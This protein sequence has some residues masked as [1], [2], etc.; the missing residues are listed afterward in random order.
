MQMSRLKT[1]ITKTEAMV[2]P[3]SY[4][5]IGAS[6]AS[7]FYLI[8]DRDNQGI[9]DINGVRQFSVNSNY[10][11]TGFFIGGVIGTICSTTV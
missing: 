9:K 7:M 8:I 5:V 10:V 1:V 6:I 2:R 4:G 3:L 11:T